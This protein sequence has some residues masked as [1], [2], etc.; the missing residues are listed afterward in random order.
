MENK[1]V[2]RSSNFELLRIIA[3]IMITVYHIVIHC[4]HVQLINSELFSQPIFYKRLSLLA[5]TLPFGI[6]ANA[7]FI[8]IAGYFLINKEHIELEKTA[9]KLL[10]QVLFATILLV[11]SSFLIYR[12]N[13][14]IL[15]NMVDIR[16]VNNMSWFVGYYFS[17]VVI[18]EL[19]L[20]KY[21]NKLSK[22]NYCSFLIVVFAITQLQWSRGLL[23]GIGDSLNLL[24]T[25]IFL[26]S[27]GGFIK[28]FDP[29]KN[30]RSY[31]FI[32]TIIVTYMLIMLSYY[33][34]TLTEIQIYFENKTQTPFIQN[35]T[36]TRFDN[37]SIITIIIAV[38]MFELC[39][40]IHM[41]NSK[42]INYIASSTFMIYLLQD[43]SF[44][45]S[46][47]L[48]SEWIETL[49]YNPVNFLIRLFKWTIFTLAIGFWAYIIYRLLC[50]ICTRLKWLVIKSSEDKK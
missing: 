1:K 40:R 34:T 12:Y 13:P 18:A 23:N 39:R 16:F 48:R 41:P 7:I 49:Y 45:Y 3:M 8:L 10:K 25:G 35:V 17:V 14:N 37:T 46:L 20:N 42:I 43:N 38:C 27:L 26:Y 47:W 36:S 6:V 33:N 50:K 32:I 30:I 2:I 5:F 22:K 44:F 9:K 28:K 4:V 11:I 24:L 29:L 21:L 31:A 15:V 19:F